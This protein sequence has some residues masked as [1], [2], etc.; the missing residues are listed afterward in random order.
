MGLI[1]E[2]IVTIESAMHAR[3]LTRIDQSALPE[4]DRNRLQKDIC[5]CDE[6]WRP[7]AEKNCPGY[8]KSWDLRTLLDRLEE[9]VFKEWLDFVHMIGDL[10]DEAVNLFF[11]EIPLWN[12]ECLL[13]RRCKVGPFDSVYYRHTERS[14][15]REIEFVELPWDK[16]TITAE[17]SGEWTFL[18]KIKASEDPKFL[19][20][21]IARLKMER[22]IA[23]SL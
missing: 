3:V 13:A 11:L 15:P 5:T 22:Q 4:E 1:H 23:S 6:N 16:P 19:K 10:R 2:I 21:S 20:Q 8:D 17:D 18:E 14:F 9:D 12:H 7:L